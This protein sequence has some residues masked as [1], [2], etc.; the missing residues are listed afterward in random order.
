MILIIKQRYIKHGGLKSHFLCVLC[1]K[2][3]ND[4]PNYQHLTD[5]KRLQTK[6]NENKPFTTD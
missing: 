3:G 2:R 6:V 1:L 5:N 4:N